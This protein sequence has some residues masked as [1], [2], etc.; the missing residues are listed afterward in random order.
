MPLLFAEEGHSNLVGLVAVCLPVLELVV[1]EG[2]LGLLRVL[3]VLLV[4]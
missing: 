2:P 1:L 4:A 3:F